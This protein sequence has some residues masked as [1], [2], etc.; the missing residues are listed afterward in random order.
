VADA[1][2]QAT[3]AHLI[4]EDTGGL[5]PLVY[6]DMVGAYGT[7]NGAVVLELASRI[8]VPRTDGSTEVKFLS[9][10]RLRCTANAAIQL[11][12]ALD[13]ALKLLEPPSAA[14]PAAAARMN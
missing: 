13:A 5:A 9:S 2:N 3:P 11:R 12:N 7:M 6:F 10:G 1:E 8:L 4:Y 14:D